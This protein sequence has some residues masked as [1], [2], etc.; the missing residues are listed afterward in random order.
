MACAPA[1]SGPPPAT[2][3]PTTVVAPASLLPVGDAR[4]SRHLLNRFAFGPRPG[5]AEKL[6]DTGM[7]RWLSEQLGPAQPASPELAAALSPYAA[8]AQEPS[9]LIASWLGEGA[10]DEPMRGPE[11]N[12]SIKPYFRE[13]LAR[14]A[15][16][17]LSRQVLSE[18][19]VE[20]VMV[21]FWLNHFNVFA[22]KGLVRVLGGDYIERA[23]RPHALG[24]FEDLLVAT[25]RHPAMLIYLDNAQSVREQGSAEGGMADMSASDSAA[26][27]NTPARRRGI[28]EN[29]ARELLELHTLGRAGGYSEDDVIATARILTGWSIVRRPKPGELPLAFVFRKKQH[30]SGDK[31]VLGESFPA[32]HGEDEG[33]RLLHLL[34]THASTA[35]HL[36][37]KLCAHFVAD[38]APPACVVDAERAFVSSGGEVRSVLWAIAHSASFW[39]APGAKLKTPLEFV[40]S[41][42]RAVRGKPDGTLE[43]AR[44]LRRLGEPLL[45]ESVPVGYSDHSLMWLSESGMLARMQFASALAFGKLGGVSADIA[46]VLPEGEVAELARAGNRELL[47]GAAS[48]STLAAIDEGLQGVDAAA[49]R[50]QLAAAWFVGSPEFQRQ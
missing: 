37:T 28:N 12:R 10:L 29:Y 36:A 41:A 49:T 1:T 18:R 17:Q 33:L 15:L 14:V 31:R 35:R 32:G 3:A 44:A 9:A 47:G 8:A 21:Q 7:E 48:P 11:F 5:E 4:A 40:V 26:S 22:P 30:D 23:L 39:A 20:E 42:L 2:L 43:L 45:E 24:R 25:A 50:R 19:Q 6:A 38:E 16:L 13:H 46:A 27:D 34:A